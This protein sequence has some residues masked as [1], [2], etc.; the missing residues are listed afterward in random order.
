MRFSERTK[1]GP[2]AGAPGPERV[3][4][5]MA[6]RGLPGLGICSVHPPTGVRT[7][8]LSNKDQGPLCPQSLQPVH[9]WA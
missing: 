7:G 5:Q 2:S 6:E 8:S 1:A 3:R 4:E 9:G